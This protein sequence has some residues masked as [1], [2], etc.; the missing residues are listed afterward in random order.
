MNLRAFE[1]MLQVQGWRVTA[2]AR[3][4][5]Q[6]QGPVRHHLVTLAGAPE[7]ELPKATYQSLIRHTQIDWKE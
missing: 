6:L 2:Q 1:T 3:T 4:I 7:A 5:R